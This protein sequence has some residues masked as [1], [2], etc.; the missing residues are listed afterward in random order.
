MSVGPCASLLT[1]F[2]QTAGSRKSIWALYLVENLLRQG[3]ALQ[4]R[5]VAAGLTVQPE[6]QAHITGRRILEPKQR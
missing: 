1:P 5:P 2:Q 4:Q 3:H 6:L